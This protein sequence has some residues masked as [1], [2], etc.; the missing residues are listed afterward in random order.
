MIRD[1]RIFLALWLALFS[2]ASPA[3]ATPQQDLV[4]FGQAH[5]GQSVIDLNFAKGPPYYLRGATGP[6]TEAR[7][8]PATC[9]DNAGNLVQV[10]ANVPCIA[11]GQLWSY[12]ARTNGLPNSTFTG[13]TSG[14]IGSGGAVPTGYTIVAS[15][16]TGGSYTL[17]MVGSGT[18]NGINYIDV[19]VTGTT[20][21]T[22]GSLT[23]QPQLGN[24][25]A[26]S[27]G[28]TWSGSFFARYTTASTGVL[29]AY[30]I[31]GWQQTGGA[32]LG[33]F[34]VAQTF[35]SSATTL[36]Q[37][38]VVS[39]WTLSNP[40]TLYVTEQLYVQFSISSTPNVTFRFGLPD[41]ELNPNLSA[42]VASAVVAAGGS[43]GT[44]GTNVNLTVTGGTCTTQPVIQGTVAGNALTAITGYGT[45][46]ACSVLPPS[47]ATVTGN[48]LTG[49]TVTLTPTSNAAQAFATPP[50]LTTNAAVTRNAS[51]LSIATQSCANPSIL[52]SGT[53]SAPTGFPVN[54]NIAQVDNGTDTQRTLLRRQ[55]STGA[56][57][58]SAIG[59]TGYSLTP[60]G[61]WA[62]SALGKLAVASMPGAQSAVFNNGTAATATAATLPTNPT[63]LHIGV[64]ASGTEN[65]NGG[66][67]EVALQCGGSLTGY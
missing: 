47:P 43:G 19:N 51:N 39:S 24:A 16:G 62:Q 44:N 18:E 64:N 55:A 53:P 54:Q 42:S 14:V 45:P 30:F 28:Q 7:S 12:E 32:F 34:S 13:F 29:Q 48:S 21:T 11:G 17:T 52:A 20:G 27:Y 60:S 63:T 1:F 40:S 15:P 59:G 31:Q 22:T 56:L 25:T 2:I 26:A 6:L 66:I 50:I 4:L 10:A 3:L 67:R 33:N 57:L 9:F 37:N 58:A 49:A 61:T 5:L 8:T 65:F 38:R 35:G 23:I 41:L 36:S 46:G